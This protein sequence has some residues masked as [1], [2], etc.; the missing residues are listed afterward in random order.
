MNI[1]IKTSKGDLHT[2][3]MDSKDDTVSLLKDKLCDKIS[4]SKDKIRLIFTGKLLKDESTLAS[5]NLEDGSTIHLVMPSGEKKAASPPTNSA[6]APNTSSTQS[7]PTQSIPTQPNSTQPNSAQPFPNLN[8]LDPNL[9]R[10]LSMGGGAP[11]EEMKSTINARIKELLKNPEQ[12]KSLMEASLSMQNIPEATKKSLMDN[13]SRFTEMAKSDPEHFNT[14]MNY[15]INNSADMPNLRDPF[16][17]GMP[18]NANSATQPNPSSISSNSSLGNS[19][20]PTANSAANPT[21]QSVMYTMPFD[22]DEARQKYS[23][24]LMELESIGYTDSEMNLIA[25]VYSDGDLTKALNLILD[26]SGEQH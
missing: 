26:W 23:E 4:A 1:L 10:E 12:M 21:P 5:Y 8:Q 20:A 9:L 3:A 18:P 14:I 24:K 15:V 13:I 25:L 7:I 6:P 17:F 11:S 16:M 2:I 19:T 22:R